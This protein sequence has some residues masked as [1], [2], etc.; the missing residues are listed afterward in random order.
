MITFDQVRKSLPKIGDG[1]HGG[2]VDY[3]NE[4]KFWYRVHFSWGAECYKA[5]KAQTKECSE[6]RRNKPLRKK[7]RKDMK[8]EIV[9]TGK[10]YASFE[11]IGIDIGCNGE[12]ARNACR[13]GK[14]CMKKWTIKC[15]EEGD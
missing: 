12:R 11:E 2:I 13:R 10:K 5:P 9:E 8:Y 6:D 3:V 1:R 15:L 7:P 14:K 4:E